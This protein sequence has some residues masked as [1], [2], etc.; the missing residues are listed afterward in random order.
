ME[1]KTSKSGI[2]KIVN[3]ANKSSFNTKIKL[4]S[5]NKQLAN[6]IELLGETVW[7]ESSFDNSMLLEGLVTREARKLLVK[8]DDVDE[9]TVVTRE[10]LWI[11][12]STLDIAID[13][14]NLY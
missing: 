13:A 1:N 2:I 10:Q 14:S 4:T 11:S 3:K 12:Q 8:L 6:N 5:L 7:V 9:P